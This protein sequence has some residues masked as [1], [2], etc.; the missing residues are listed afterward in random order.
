MPALML[1][2]ERGLE[3]GDGETA[4]GFADRAVAVGPQSV[5][6]WLAR[7]DALL[8]LDRKTEAQT[9]LTRA[10]QLLSVDKDHGAPADRLERVQQALLNGETPPPRY[11]DGE[12]KDHRSRSADDAPPRRRSRKAKRAAKPRGYGGGSTPFD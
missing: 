6:A 10:V 1:M 8:L 12:V 5:S 11:T 9:C 3:A 2:A 4:L 7:G